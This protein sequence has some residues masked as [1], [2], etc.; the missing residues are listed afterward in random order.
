MKVRSAEA[1]D[2]CY[3]FA[4]NCGTWSCNL[5]DN[6]IHYGIYKLLN[7]QFTWHL[8]G[9][10]D[11]KF[12]NWL[13]FAN[14][15]NYL[16]S[17]W[18]STFDALNATHI[19]SVIQCSKT[20]ESLQLTEKEF[21]IHQQNFFSLG[22]ELLQI[23]GFVKRR[24]DGGDDFR[25]RRSHVRTEC[26]TE[27][28][29]HTAAFENLNLKFIQRRRVSG[30][31]ESGEHRCECIVINVDQLITRSCEYVDCNGCGEEVEQVNEWSSDDRILKV[32]EEGVDQL[33][34]FI[35]EENISS[36]KVTMIENSE[37]FDWTDVIVD[38]FRR[39]SSRKPVQNE[40]KISVN[41]I[42][43]SRDD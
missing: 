43:Q 20:V 23:L 30:V 3:H 7:K 16:N 33:V 11:K 2:L 41:L 18:K 42:I 37:V 31:V 24:L 29:L 19:A 27:V 34:A 25:F 36:V 14:E 22:F 1:N 35:L 12:F 13:A 21:L 40:K 6:V 5:V 39:R 38:D 26:Q 28:H 17:R 8:F 10:Q 9:V 32:D 15:L 4:I